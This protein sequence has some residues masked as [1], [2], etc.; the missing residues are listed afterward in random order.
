MRGDPN[1]AFLFVGGGLQLGRL[2]QLVKEKQLPNV[3]FLPYQKRSHLSYSLSAGHV[4]L[5]TL[6]PG[7]EGMKLPAKMFGIMAVAKPMIYLGSQE[8]EVC[9]VIREHGIGVHVEDGDVEGFLS[10][11]DVLR[12]DPSLR[13]AMGERA[14]ALFEREYDS[15][16]LIARF[17]SLLGPMLEGS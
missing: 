3:S 17:E 11:L 9:D 14:R 8:S 15:E 16:V 4:H 10:A 6:K 13:Q 12:K 1:V 5:V 2:K 7:V